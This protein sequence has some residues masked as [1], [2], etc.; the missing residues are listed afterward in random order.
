MSDFLLRVLL[1]IRVLSISFFGRIFEKITSNFL[2]PTLQDLVA[3][4]YK[5][6]LLFSVFFISPVYSQSIHISGKVINQNNEAIENVFVMLRYSDGGL[7]IAYTQ[8]SATGLF[9]LKKDL[10]EINPDSLELYFSHLGFAPQ[11]RQIS[12]IDELLIIELAETSIELKEVIVTNRNIILRSDTVIYTVSAFS[13]IEDRTI[14]DVLRRMPGI[15]VLPSGQIRYQGQDLSK[16]YIEGSDLLGGRYGLATNNISHRNVLRV[17]ILENHQPIRALQGLVFLEA[18][19]MN[20]VLDEDAKSRWAG[21]IKAGVGIPDLWIAE[22]VAMKFNQATQT[23]NTYKGNNTGNESFESGQFI[24]PDDLLPVINSQLSTYIRVSP[25]VASDIG[26]SRSIFNKTNSLTS[27]SLVKIR[28]HLDLTFELIGKSDHRNSEYVSQTTYFLGNEHVTIEDNTEN[29]SNLTKSFIGAV[30]LKSNQE[31]Y[32]Y[33]NHFEFSYDRG[34]PFINTVGS[35]ANSQSAGI[36]SRKFSNKFDILKRAGNNFFTFRSNNEYAAKPQFLEVVKDGQSPARENIGLSSFNSNNIA[37]YA[38]TIRKIRIQTQTGLLYQYRQIENERNEI[39]YSLN[40]NKLKLDFIPSLALDF[41]DFR[42]NLSGVL[43]FQNLSIE[44][45]MRQFY[46]FDPRLSFSWMPSSRFNASTSF[47]HSKIFPDENMFFHGNIM[48]N[49]RSLTTGYFDF[50][51]GKNANFSTRMEYKDVVKIF[52]ADLRVTLSKRRQTKIKEQGFEG[53]YILNYFSPGNQTSEMFS[54]SGS[55]SKGIELNRTVASIYPAFVHNKSSISR[56][57]ITIPFSSDS[58]IF[59]GRL[60]SRVGKNSNLTYEASYSHSINRMELNR[61]YFSSNRLSQSLKMAYSPLKILQLSYTF[62]HYCN[63]LT[64]N[65]Y[66]NFI[67]SDVSASYLPGNRWEFAF[68][69]KNIFD[70]KEYSYFIENELTAFYRNYTIRPRNV[71]LS[72]SYM[73]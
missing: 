52:F 28:D 39:A 58:Y 45:R 54:V 51:T 25:S 32:Y 30:R 26:S 16:F 23:L 35:F 8:T 73:F 7:I 47:S 55:L 29:A 65:N 5:I 40:T 44:N 11:T 37:G 64:R 6:I 17:E 34:D 50:S 49:Y 24:L 60:S 21:N 13:S 66:K 67:F 71:L 53:D 61:Q 14:G 9:E 42:I 63:E 18:P 20:L 15:E 31:R 3:M 46:G 69:V 48:N 41:Y 33:N 62:D 59:R 72:V 22:A 56:N 27:N 12:N 10:H 19:A 2:H 70:E 68:S 38:I 1:K 4:K 57:G 36:E 43:F